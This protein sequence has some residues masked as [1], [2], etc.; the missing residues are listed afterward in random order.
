MSDTQRDG[1][2]LF[3]NKNKAG[4]KHPDWKGDITVAGV[5]YDL[6]GW[7]KTTRNGDVFISIRPSEYRERQ[8]RQEG[9]PGGYPPEGNAAPRRAAPRLPADLDDEIPF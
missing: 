9:R 6:A 8:P 7:E 2:A 5:K 3:R 4:E 1:G